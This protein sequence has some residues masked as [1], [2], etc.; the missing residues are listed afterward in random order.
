MVILGI[1][2]TLL[3][4]FALVL[5]QVRLHPS[6]AQQPLL[7]REAPVERPAAGLI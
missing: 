1:L 4:C 6:P 3:L 7:W 5:W 2:T